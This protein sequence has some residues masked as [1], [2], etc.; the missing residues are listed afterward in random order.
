MDW[1][2]EQG[3]CI[4]W[5]KQQPS[6]SV[7]LIFTS[8]PYELARDYLENG[9]NLNISRKTEEWVAWMI[10][11]TRECSRVCTGLIALVVEGQTRK[12]RYSAGPMLLM[13]DLHRQGFNLRKPAVFRR[14]GIPGSG[15][16]DWL[17]NNW[18][19]IICVTRPGRLPWSDNKAMGHIPKWAPGGEMSYRQADG[20]RRNKW[21]KSPQQVT[22]TS[23]NRNKDGSRDSLVRPGDD[24]PR[25]VGVATSGYKSGD[26]A[27]LAEYVPPAIANPGNVIQQMYSARE[28]SEML[29]EPTDV[30]DCTVGG[31]QMGH[32]LAHD[33]EA[34]FPLVL[35]EFF[36]KS[37]CKPG[38]LVLD[39]FS[40]SATTGHAAIANGRRYLGCDLRR[41]QVELG[42]RRLE[43]VELGLMEKV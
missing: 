3:D 33:N 22:G 39:P 12:F 35:A 6:D 17:R 8:P 36:V 31:G 5:L 37:F 34:P 42:R 41:S 25:A 24:E 4:E 32:P 1:R 38:G 40:G 27:T 9:E 23:G 29:G 30:I 43:E 14:C 13:A 19:P 7:D 15:G 18:E 28:V 21:G 2:I 11:V 20:A 16:T 26:T 10:E